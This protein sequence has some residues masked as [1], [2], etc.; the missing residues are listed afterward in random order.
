MAAKT[1]EGAENVA[2]FMLLVESILDV[3]SVPDPTASRLDLACGD[4][5]HALDLRT[6]VEAPRLR[7]TAI[8]S[9]A[10]RDALH[11]ERVRIDAREALLLHVPA[12]LASRINGAPAPLLAVLDVADQID[13]G[14]HVVHV[15]RYRR[16]QAGTPAPEQLGRRCP[17]CSVEIT[18]DTVVCVHDC[19]AVLHLEPHGLRPDAELLRCAELGSCPDCSA[20]VSMTTG[21]VYTPED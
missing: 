4:G 11:F 18:P 9:E 8:D 21:L 5:V 2:Q 16:V 19:G 20:P 7:A 12:G 14:D 15:S 6:T 1:S 17:V 3:A 10:P 13:L